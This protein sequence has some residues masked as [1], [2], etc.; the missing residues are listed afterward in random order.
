[1]DTESLKARIRNRLK[2][3]KVDRG[4]FKV[5][6]VGDWQCKEDMPRFSSPDGRAYY[7]DTWPTGFRYVGTASEAYRREHGCRSRTIFEGWYNDEFRSD[8][9]VGHVLQLPARDGKP[10]YVIAVDE[11]DS[12]GK[13]VW[14]LRM[15]DSMS[16]AALAADGAAERWAEIN[17]EENEKFQREQ[18]IEESREAIISIRSDLRLLVREMKAA[19]RMG[20]EGFPTLCRALRS[21]IADLRE[22][23]REA[24]ETIRRLEV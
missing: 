21:R 15:F 3:F 18:E 14:P 5:P 2:R 9:S 10:C 1:M 16:D 4:G 11:T 7:C 24:Y 23:S 17:R 12:E 6:Y 8:L 22:Q 20:V 13:T 19:R